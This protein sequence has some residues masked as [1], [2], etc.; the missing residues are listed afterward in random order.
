MKNFK[1]EI[2]NRFVRFGN[3]SDKKER[4]KIAEN[5]FKWEATPLDKTLI[6]KKHQ[7]SIN[8][9]VEDERISDLLG[10][11]PN[12]KEDFFSK[13]LQMLEEV[14][15]ISEEIQTPEIIQ[16]ENFIKQL[17]KRNTENQ[18]LFLYEKSIPKNIQ[19]EFKLNYDIINNEPQELKSQKL[20]KLQ[21]SIL[22]EW[23]NCVQSNKFRIRDRKN[24][25]NNAQIEDGY[26]EHFKRLSIEDFLIYWKKDFIQQFLKKTYRRK[27][28]NLTEFNKQLDEIK[29]TI[30]EKDAKKVELFNNTLICRLKED[31]TIEKSLLQIEQIDKKRKQ[32][33]EELY[34]EIEKF[35]EFLKLI[36]PFVDNT[37]SYGRLWD[38]SKGKWKG[39]N[40]NMLKEYGE[41]LNKRKELVELA[42]VLGRYRKAEMELKEEEYTNWKVT[43]KFK[44]NHSG[45]SELIGITESN[46]LNNLLA[47]EI[48]LFSDLSTESIFFKKF[49]EKKLQSYQFIDKESYKSSQS[50]NDKKQVQVEKDKGPF[51]LAIDTSGSMH[52]EPE[53]L[54]KIIAFAITKIAHRDKRKA[55]LI[56]F[57]TDYEMFELTDFQN[58]LSKLIHFLQMSF[59][60]GTDVSGAVKEAVNQMETN[61]Y[62]KADLLIITDGIFAQP[63]RGILSSIEGLKQRGNKFNTLIIGQSQNAS[64]LNFCDNV[65][66][67]DLYLS[68]I[69]SLVRQINSSY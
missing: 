66:F 41:L 31:F 54:A 23:E 33:L 8:L 34:K 29:N 2:L 24:D 5:L 30:F 36:E 6:D 7:E 9:L 59:N 56:S 64:A 17:E 32:F 12:L 11:Y 37:K 3:V 26:I 27:D 48:A 20:E 16:K 65:W 44:I 14:E 50:F 68:D 62:E 25:P 22:R 39:I 67:H 19:E 28:L 63:N 18:L 42:E 49:S 21:S 1:S 38:L 46:D 69:K 47:S 52:G 15:S 60:G 51:I 10:K 57:S 40:F 58:S 53:F 43:N 55:M 35:K 45:K 61:N 13:A 4:E